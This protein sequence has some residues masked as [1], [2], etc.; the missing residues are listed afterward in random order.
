MASERIIT[1]LIGAVAFGVLWFGWECWKLRR[2]GG[3]R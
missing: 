3:L 2:A 1:T